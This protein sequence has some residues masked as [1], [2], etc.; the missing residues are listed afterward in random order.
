MLCVF[1]L[2]AETSVVE[3]VSRNGWRLDH[4]VEV[5]SCDPNLF[6]LELEPLE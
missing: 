3:G 4:A 5:L 6:L 1:L 2:M